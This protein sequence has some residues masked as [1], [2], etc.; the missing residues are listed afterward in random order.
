MA[1]QTVHEIVE[2]WKRIRDAELDYGISPGRAVFYL[3]ECINDIMILG[4]K[5]D[6]LLNEYLERGRELI[7][8]HKT[9]AAGS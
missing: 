7:K 8:L 9:T 3:E 5:S 4:E 6:R 2:K 1:E